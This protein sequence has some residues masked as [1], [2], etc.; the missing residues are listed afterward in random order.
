VILDPTT[1]RECLG[2]LTVMARELAPTTLI[3]T[4][5]ARLGSPDAVIS[6]LQSLPQTDDNGGERYRYVACDVSQRVR[7]LPDDPNCFERAFAALALL[8]VLDPST[9]RMLVTIEQPARHTGVVEKRGG[10]WYALDLFP[11]RNF[12]L[13]ELGK[14]VLLG[15]HQYVGEPVLSA[16]GAGAV[17]DQ[18]GDL[19]TNAVG[20]GKKNE[21]KQQPPTS[22]PQSAKPAAK[23]QQAAG[24][25]AQPS[26]G[27]PGTGF[28]D[29]AKGILGAGAKSA[30]TTS[31]KGENDEEARS[32]KSEL[33]NAVGGT[34]AAVSDGHA[35]SP[36]AKGQA[37]R[38]GHWG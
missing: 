22:K 19:E 25:Q 5:A 6:W 12:D 24:G 31:T 21:K 33:P 8:E 4:V 38:W 32:R 10:R 35:P 13:G 18:L 2:Q 27:K 16:Y 20:R 30:D 3:R 34:V 37:K 1:D 15:G 29:V 28:L 7:L 11:R 26:G 23:P 14:D 36:G 9:T 17:A